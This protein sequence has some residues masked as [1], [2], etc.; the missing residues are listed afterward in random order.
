MFRRL[1][2]SSDNPTTGHFSF[3][4]KS[5]AFR[6]GDTV[7]AALLAAGVNE[8]RSTSL[9]GGSRGPFCL[10]G[11]CFDCLVAIDGRENARACMEPASEGVRVEPQN[12]AT[13]LK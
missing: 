12:G 1:E 4:G 13:S 5:I 3:A 2:K 6:P 10:M 7:A 8:F 11:V 9:S